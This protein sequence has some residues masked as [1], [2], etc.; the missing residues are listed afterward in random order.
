MDIEYQYYTNRVK[1]REEI[2]ELYQ[3]DPGYRAGKNK[4]LTS[5]TNCST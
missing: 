1:T 2:W 3:T 4:Y 5:S